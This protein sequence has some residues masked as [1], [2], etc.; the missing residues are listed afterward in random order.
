VH[1]ATFHVHGGEV[2]GLLGPNGAG[3]ST[4]MRML[5]TL[6]A[7]TSGTATICGFDVRTQ[8]ASVRG[9]LGY[10]SATSGLPG[11]LTCREVLRTFA[12]LQG[13]EEPG[14]AVDDALHRFGVLPYAD[15]F[16]EGLSTGMRQRV[17]I[18]CAAIHRPSVLILDEPT[19]GLDIVS[20][21]NLLGVVERLRDHGTAVIYST[22]ILSEAER[23]CDRI[24]IIFD[25]RV[26]AVDRGSAL[27]KAA[28]ATDLRDA[29]LKIIG[30][31]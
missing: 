1:D 10:L 31:Q 29:F 18:A 17:R 19:S 21:D 26:L 27:I 5:A 30:R 4:T 6:V 20:A 25:G 11:R 2:L 8:A 14:R 13:V 12:R 16:V 24:A 3:K 9:N 15:R 22:H 28:R 23:L 7:P